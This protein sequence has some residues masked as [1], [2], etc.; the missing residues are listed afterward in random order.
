MV[1][2]FARVEDAPHRWRFECAEKVI[3]IWALADATLRVRYLA[4]G[5]SA[6][7]RSFALERP[8]SM[9]EGAPI[10]AT[11]T[12]DGARL[13]T[14]DFT[15]DVTPSCGLRVRGRDGVVLLDDLASS[16]TSVER[17]TSDG[18]PFY[19]LGEKTGALDRRG[20]VLEF[21][22]TDA[23]DPAFGGFRP[24]Q[25]PLYASIPFFVSLREERAY[26]LFTDDA[27]RLEID[28]A[29]GGPRYRIR[30]DGRRLDQYLFLGPRISDVVRRYT[31]LTGRAPLPPRW[32]LGYHQS[33]WGYSPGARVEEIARG[34]R[35]RGIPLDAIW[36]DIQHMD[37]F[38]TFTFDP[39]TF[40]DPDAMIARL[41]AIGVR[42]IVIADPGLKVDPG[43]PIYD[44]AIAGDLVLRHPDG[45]AFE[46]IAWPGASVF[47]DFTSPRAR[48]FWGDEVRRL[49]Q[50]G[51]AG[52][53]LDV[54]EPTVFPESGGAGEIP[55]DLPM[56]GD[57]IPTTMA[58]GH[59]VY[60]IHEARATFEALR[61]ERRPFVLTRAGSAGI[62]R[63]AAM[64]TGDAPSTWDSLRQTPA[65][66]MSLGLSGVPFVGSD[67]G[68]Y[69]GGATP[70]LFARWMAVGAFSP[71]ARGHVTNGVPDQEPWAFG[72]EV[73][74]IGRARLRERYRWL[75]YLYSL[76]DEARLTG[77]PVLRPLVWEFQDDAS[78]RSVGDQMMLGPFL[79]IAPVLEEG[80]T[81]RSVRLPEGRWFELESS[82][83]YEGPGTIDVG[84][85][86][87]A[88]PTFVREG[89]ILIRRDAV[90][91]TGEDPGGLVRID[92]YP[93][94]TASAFVHYEDAGDGDGP[95]AR[96]RYELRATA[97]GAELV[98]GERTGDFAI[99]SR[100]LDV[101]VHRVDAAVRGVRRGGEELIARSSE[102]ELVG[103]DYWVDARDRT[104]VVR[105]PDGSAQI[106]FEYDPA[107]AEARP[108]VELVLEVEVPASTAHDRSICVATNLDGWTAHQPLE[109]IGPTT[110]R[111]TIRV[112]R[113]EWFFYKFTRG[114]WETVEK[115]EGCA[116]A[117]NRY[118][119][120][121]AHP[122]RRDRVATW[123][124][125]CPP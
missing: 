36:L 54:N 99:A 60:A 1:P 113:G 56:E 89:A 74:D 96:T 14:G 114:D 24:D 111:G 110:A 70:E 50:R 87:A 104:L 59:N 41:E 94:A 48:A 58:E 88:V 27:H 81:R 105:V 76:F 55:L 28:L 11:G 63:Y 47:L 83:I 69:S 90:E 9:L 37:G 116:E 18:E 68:G 21:W 122:V 107:I 92:L 32:A 72:Q 121:T 3:S 119:F 85:T 8:A 26:G 65:M 79:L 84:V 57:G 34:F 97:T 77:A 44:R 82:A 109:W 71:F 103:G 5:D 95:S 16:P 38:R 43:W 42:T 80:A 101:R 19:G 30:T 117:A 120:G 39:A 93:A 61:G 106:V 49:E 98:V 17:A 86:L 52:V 112:P 25:D 51:V 15:I 7:D 100:M 45:R 75:D 10:E 29:S 31:A 20:R 6:P 62:Q 73:L 40:P 108:D 53:W 46:G 35:D 102:S 33:R 118:G 23:Y 123:R 66:L 12:A 91:H 124:D 64:W 125:A 78:L 2:D 4:P 115:Y 67:I 13:C 22:N